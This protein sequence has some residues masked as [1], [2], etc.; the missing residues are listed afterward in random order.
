MARWREACPVIAS[1]DHA[2]L[3]ASVVLGAVLATLVMG[4]GCSAPK[5]LAMPMDCIGRDLQACDIEAS[6]S[7]HPG[8][9]YEACMTRRGL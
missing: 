4:S 8:E 2:W 6:H 5:R 3:L 9:A 7:E 1:E